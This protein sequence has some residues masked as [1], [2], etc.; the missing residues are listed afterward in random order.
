MGRPMADHK[1]KSYQSKGEFGDGTFFFQKCFA[2]VYAK[3]YSLTY[4]P[5]I[6]YFSCDFF[7][8]LFP[9]FTTYKRKFNFSRLLHESK[10]YT[11]VDLCIFMVLFEIKTTFIYVYINYRFFA[12]TNHSLSL[13]IDIFLKNSIEHSHLLNIYV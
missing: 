6:Q 4:G 11:L 10:K 8:E 5:F 12:S 13:W 2:F 1:K 9:K 7:T 3:K